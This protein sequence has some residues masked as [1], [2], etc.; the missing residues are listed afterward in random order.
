MRLSDQ[1]ALGPS[2]VVVVV[3]SSDN[4]TERTVFLDADEVMNLAIGTSHGGDSAS[5]DVRLSYR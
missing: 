2:E 4:M 5:H 1:I 3:K